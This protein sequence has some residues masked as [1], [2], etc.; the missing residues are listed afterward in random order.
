M[1][2]QVPVVYYKARLNEPLASAACPPAGL[3][4]F[5]ALMLLRYDYN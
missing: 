3:A 2:F 4:G 1:A 5:Y